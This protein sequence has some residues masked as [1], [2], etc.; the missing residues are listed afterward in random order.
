VI[1][2]F[3]FEIL[4]SNLIGFYYTIFAATIQWISE[5]A[6]RLGGDFVGLFGP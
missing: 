2:K 3:I 6:T 1:S 5:I 4:I